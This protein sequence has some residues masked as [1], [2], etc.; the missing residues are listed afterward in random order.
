[1]GKVVE[2]H[3]E[4]TSRQAAEQ[5]GVTQQRIQTLFSAGDLRGRK[6]AGRLVIDTADVQARLLRHPGAGR[7]QTARVA[8]ATL[9]ELSGERAHWLS[10]SERSRLRATIRR[11]NP[12]DIALRVRRRATLN[13]Y[14]VL[15]TYLE[16][17]T[18][19]TALVAGGIS[20]TS[21]VGADIVAI[22]FAEVYTDTATHDRVVTQYALAQASDDGDVNVNLRVVDTD[23]TF[24][25]EGRSQM[26]GAVVAA[27]LMEAPES[28]TRRAGTQLLSDLLSQF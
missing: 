9:W 21:A 15:P 17:L 8:W 6:V 20:A 18:A 1:L 23:L 25:L 22:G 2:Q 10:P 11:L 16:R 24:L 19:D 4:I 26:P 14:R 7:P 12:D 13:Q 5:L 27:D 28:R 3:V